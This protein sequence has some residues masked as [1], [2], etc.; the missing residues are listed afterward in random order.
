MEWVKVRDNNTND[1]LFIGF[2]GTCIII[3]AILI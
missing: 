3:I 2:I 1:I